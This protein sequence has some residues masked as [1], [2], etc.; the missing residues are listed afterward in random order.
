[1]VEGNA[2]EGQCGFV[3]L[4]RLYPEDDLGVGRYGEPG[5]LCEF[6][7]ELTGGPACMPQHDEEVVRILAF[8]DCL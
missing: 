5:V 7:L 3:A 4:L 6:L 1:M 2:Q 8:A